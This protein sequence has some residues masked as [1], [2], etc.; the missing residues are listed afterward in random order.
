MIKH[1]RRGLLKGSAGLLAATFATSAPWV[2][3]ASSEVK[4]KLGHPHPD[5]DSW[6][7]A[8]LWLA[9][10][11]KERTGGAIS[12]QVYSNGI[13][14]SDQTMVNA[15]RGGSIDIALTGNPFFSGLAPELNALDLPYLFN[16]RKH[17]AAVLDGDLGHELRGKL[18]ASDLKALATWE[19]GWRNVTNSRHAVHTPDDIKGLKLRTT[20]NPAHIR[21]FELLGAI[22]TPMAFTELFTALEMRSID[23]QEN[24]VTLILNANLFEVQR[25]ISLTQ[26]AFTSAPLVMNKPKFD[27]LAPEHQ[28]ILLEAALEGAQ[29][30]RK[31][32]EDK[33]ASSVAALK[34][35]GMEVVEDLDQQAFRAIVAD[36]VR[37]EFVEKFGPEIPD[38]IS[39]LA[40]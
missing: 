39:A 8:S 12:I 6:H 29:M 7:E 40:S 9:E 23:G 19:V 1:T 33:E 26:H 13:L 2:A 4:L 34:E 21:A 5:S 27:G 15:A 36:T 20:P 35:H 18:E 3:R 28:T 25:Y 30:Q 32:N 16:D 14:G 37:A 31:L 10:T 24:P 17:V 22:P 11:V 38:R